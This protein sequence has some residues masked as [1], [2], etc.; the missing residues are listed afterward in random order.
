M[1]MTATK[2]KPREVVSVDELR[3]GD[4]LIG[5]VHDLT[6]TKITEMPKSRVLEIEDVNGYGVVDVYRAR[7]T[8]RLYIQPRK[9]YAVQALVDSYGSPCINDESYADDLDEAR[10][11]AKRFL[12]RRPKEV[13]WVDIIEAEFPGK[14]HP[15]WDY[16]D[17]IETIDA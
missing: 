3:L 14:L 9:H 5:Q 17:H 6:I 7:R 13:Q 11:S 2:T 15:E 16:G 8:T 1:S 10:E 12:A 4:T